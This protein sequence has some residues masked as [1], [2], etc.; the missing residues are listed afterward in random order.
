MENAIYYYSGT[1]NSYSSS[2]LLSV[3][4]NDE[5]KCYKL[6]SDTYKIDADTLIFVVPTYAYGLPKFIYNLFKEIDIKAN[7][8]ILLATCGTITGHLFKQAYSL[9]KKR[10][11][12]LCYY[13]SIECVDNYFAIFK[14]DS[15]EDEKAKLHEQ[16]EKVREIAGEINNM[17][18][19]PKPNGSFFGCLVSAVFRAF[20][21]IVNLA[22]RINKN[23]CTGCGLCTINCQVKAISVKDGKAKTKLTECQNCQG[24]IN[25]CP[26]KAIS[27]MRVNKKMRRYLHPDHKISR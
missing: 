20:L 17:K 3:L 9:L 14:R 21:P 27:F 4:L 16:Y 10:G 19:S 25:V 6:L 26:Q 22:M 15:I 11:V 18:I 8:V 12:T 24:C 5:Y 13:N 23:E 1:G 7:R 2:V